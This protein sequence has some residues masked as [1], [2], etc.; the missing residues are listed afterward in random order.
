MK[1]FGGPGRKK[2]RCIKR[3]CQLPKTVKKIGKI[4]TSQHSEDISAQSAPQ[5]VTVFL[6]QQERTTMPV[7]PD[8]NCFFR[9]LS[10]VL[11]GHQEKHRELRN[12]LVHFISSHK[13]MFR[14]FMFSVLPLE[15]HLKKMANHGTW[16]THLEINAAACFLQIPIY[17]CT[18]RTETLVYYWELYKPLFT[19]S[20]Y[21]ERIAVRTSHIELAHIDRCHYEVITMMDGNIPKQP[22]TLNESVH[23]VDLT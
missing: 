10:A 9:A 22:P 8:G 3:K 16:A 1:K 18:Q 6:S 17:V 21:S 14:K 13:E 20:A 19:E 5:R 4:K 7:Q 12:Y 2:Q 15:E 23:C 11:Y